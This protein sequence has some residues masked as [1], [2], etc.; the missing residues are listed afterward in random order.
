MTTS[1]SASPLRRMGA[2]AVAAGSLFTIAGGA[3]W[4][5]VTSQL[6]EEQITV[7]DNAPFLP[8]AE[9]QG[10]VSAYAESL[11]IQANAKRMSGGR[12][13]A[14]INAEISTLDGASPEAAELRKKGQGLSTAA[15]LRTSLLTSVI[16]YGVSALAV[17]VGSLFMLLGLHLRRAGRDEG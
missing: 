10:P 4:Y 6:R 1:H 16:A 11:A 17:G 8:G 12:T 9:V 5:T 13:F 2:I 14:E 7:P 15:S 3:A